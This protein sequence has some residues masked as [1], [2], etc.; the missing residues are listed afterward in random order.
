MSPTGNAHSWPASD[1]RQ[2][3]RPSSLSPRRDVDSSSTRERGMSWPSPGLGVSCRNCIPHQFQGCRDPW[4]AWRRS[5]ITRSRSFGRRELPSSI[6]PGL[7]VGLGNFHLIGFGVRASGF[8]GVWGLRALKREASE[9]LGSVR[10]YCLYR[11][12]YLWLIEGMLSY[13]WWEVLIFK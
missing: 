2:E 6:V 13:L 10:D 7:S 3:P 5:R 1:R 11:R 12:V 9:R 8:G 4:R